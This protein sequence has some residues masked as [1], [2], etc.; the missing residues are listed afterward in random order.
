MDLRKRV[1]YFIPLLHLCGGSILTDIAV[2]EWAAGVSLKLTFPVGE[3]SLNYKFQQC[4]G[5]ALTLWSLEPRTLEEVGRW[6]G[7]FHL[8][9]MSACHFL[10]F[11]ETTHRHEGWWTKP[12]EWRLSSKVSWC[13]LGDLKDNKKIICWFVSWLTWLLIIQMGQFCLEGINLFFCC[14]KD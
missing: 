12:G 6:G 13:F 7:G 14:S 5:E 10:K 4:L 1:C 3:K 11:P 8:H 9:R 2:V